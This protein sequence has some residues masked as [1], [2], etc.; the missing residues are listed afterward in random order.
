MSW[1]QHFA[2]LRGLAGRRRHDEELDEE[3]RA[4]LEMEEQENRAKGMSPEEAHF[5]ARRKFGN[6]VRTEERARE[7]WRWVW[8]ETLAQDIRFGLRQLRRNP[9]F[10][11]V[12]VLTLALGIGANT[13]VFSVV[14]ALVL[15]QLPVE[16]PQRLVFLQTKGGG[17]SHS[18]PNYRE[19][20]D[21]N[22]AFSGL[23]G[24]RISPMNLEVGGGP[25]RVWGYLATGNYFDVL[26]V[27]PEAGRFF[28]QE[29]DQ[30]PGASPF[31]VLSYDCWQRRFGGD[32]KI[33]GGTIQI[34]RLSYT[35]FGVA[36][37]GFHGTELFYWPEVWV[38]MMMQP[39]IEA[40]NSSLD[41]RTTFDTW[42]I[43]RLKPGV[44][45]AQAEAD[46]NIIAAD[47]A[48]EYPAPN[49]GLQLKL[50]RPGLIGDALRGPVK[51][52]TT[53][54]LGLAVLVLLTACANLASLLMARAAD[55][56]REIAIRLAIGAGRGRVVRQLLTETLLLSLAAGSAGYGLAVLL[57][58]LLTAWH[59]PMDF[60]VQFDAIPD[61]RVFLFAFGVSV[62]AG[63]LF[64]LGPA[65]Q[66]SRGNTSAVLKGSLGRGKGSRR[67][68]LRDAL[69]ALQVAFC[70]VLISSC[71][72]SLRGL[73]H[74]LTM[75]LGFQPRGVTVVGF[76]LGLAGYSEEQ[77]RNFQRRA[78]EA[79]ANLPGAR[80]AAYSNSVPL[81]IDQSYN[82]IYPEDQPNLTASD[83]HSAVQ[84]QISPGFFAT[85]GTKLIAG[86]DF[87]WHDDSSA[88]PVA[89]INRA[90]SKQ[91]LHT[92]SPIGK[93][94][95]YG[96][97]GLVVEVVG[98]VED[99]KYQALAESPQPVVFK[100]IVQSY[101]STTTLLVRSSTPE[102]Q[103]VA[104]IRKAIAELD[105]ELPLYGTGSLEQMLGFALF[106]ARAAA[107]ALSAFGVLAI[108]LAATGIHGL[109][110]YA[111]ARRVHEIGIRMAIGARPS[112]VLWL[113]LARMGALLAAGAALGLVLALA[114][115]QVLASVVYQA[116]PRDPLVLMAV[117]V[118]VLMIGLLS[119]WAPARRA[120]KVDPMVALRY[121]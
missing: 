63:V 71:L 39:L 73:Q 72:L 5:A 51:A 66:A 90:F 4:H 92:D 104:P 52:F 60:P 11:A 23:V 45:P 95:H 86:R 8:L 3:I 110:S 87:N 81:S 116:S 102:A 106:P 2:K 98:V 48:R 111:V 89:L 6:V 55:R 38:P 79:A 30:R 53:G 97:S 10:T 107:V 113:V 27:A 108:M 119:C 56:E 50:A 69:V 112:Q 17:I 24:Y 75:P 47:L 36:P 96:H 61:W 19:L 44:S 80:S 83:A 78:L 68:T 118:T 65:R 15:R 57:A 58:R 31:A 49:K 14:N 33:I 91:I 43:G 46:L 12:A 32:P 105:P 70:F 35:V 88:P 109:V 67:L 115:G 99:G 76:D 94:F 42:V 40:G 16:N 26:G 18:F 25:N 28:H 100:P 22:N 101:N 62:G 7:M 64:G 121:E 34:N 59:A 82:G 20:R 77:G 29:D 117:I 1:K 120:T 13:L 9:G 21:R 37:R 54:V 41:E 93:R 74:A 85:M 114:G 84:Y 103:M